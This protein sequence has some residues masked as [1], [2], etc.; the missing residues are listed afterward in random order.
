MQVHE[1]VRLALAELLL[2]LQLRE[3]AFPN[4]DHKHTDAS[5]PPFV[6]TAERDYLDPGG[7]FASDQGILSVILEVENVRMNVDCSRKIE[8]R[9]VNLA[10]G[11]LYLISALIIPIQSEIT[12]GQGIRA[13]A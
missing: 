5:G 12:R 1:F 9:I 8:P 11:R 6:E 2:S 7:C 4:P 3:R 13:C 10:P